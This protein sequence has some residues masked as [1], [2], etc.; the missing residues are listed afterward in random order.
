MAYIIFITFEFTQDIQHH[1]CIG[2]RGNSC[3]YPFQDIQMADFLIYPITCLTDFIQDGNGHAQHCLTDIP[4]MVNL[5]FQICFKFPQILPDRRHIQFPDVADYIP[6]SLHGID[7][8]ITFY[9]LKFF[10]VY[11]VHLYDR[12]PPIAVV[13]HHFKRPVK[14][15]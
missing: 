10:L 4:I 6:F 8:F 12:Q 7:E 14:F 1:G 11:Y 2:I 9:R 3:F 15:L 5:L 13:L